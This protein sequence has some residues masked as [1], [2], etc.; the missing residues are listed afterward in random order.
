MVRLGVGLD[1]DR[2]R[3]KLFTSAGQKVT[4]SFPTEN[5]ERLKHITL[6]GILHTELDATLR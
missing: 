2:E 5:K 4:K 6:S 3:R 1:V